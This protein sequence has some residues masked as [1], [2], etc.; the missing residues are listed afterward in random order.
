M[1]TIELEDGTTVTEFDVQLMSVEEISEL[2][3]KIQSEIGRCST[4]KRHLGLTAKSKKD[5]KTN[6][7]YVRLA[8]RLTLLSEA[9]S[10]IG[11]IKRKKKDVTQKEF[12]WYR[13]FFNIAKES[14]KEKVIEKLVS[15]TNSKMNYNIF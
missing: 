1:K 8:D 12:E 2:T 3:C 13:K 11:L 14:M 10:W 15:E 4:A 9:Q 5:K 6:Q 7:K